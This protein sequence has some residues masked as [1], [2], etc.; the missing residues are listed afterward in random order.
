VTIRAAVFDRDGVLTTFDLAAA[1][2][3][4]RP[5]LP[6]GLREIVAR[7][8]TFGKQ[9]GFPRS[10]AEEQEFFARFWNSIAD[11]CSS[12]PA[13]RDELLR[14]DYTTCMAA[15]A[16]ARPALEAARRNGLKI[17]VLSNFSLA[18]LEHSL[19][20][21]GLSD[22]ID[23]ACAATVI[24]ASKPQP[25]A[26]FTIAQQ[27]GVAAEECLFFDDE[28][29][30]VEGARAAGM[31]AYQVD[32]FGMSAPSRFTLHSLAEVATLVQSE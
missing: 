30:C 7:W 4:F 19:E 16:D 15:Y 31:C 11:E 20:A 14:F 12:P 29:V 27:L 13:I 32:R 9:N 18:S 25:K 5:R 10:V 22:L 17:G 23:C 3:F 26:Y 1:D 28:A 2:A 6:L 24:G 8:E 21:T